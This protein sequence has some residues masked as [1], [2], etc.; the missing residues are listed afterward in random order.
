MLASPS[1]VRSGQAIGS[2]PAT[3]RQFTGEQFARLR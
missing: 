2:L 3:S 1:S